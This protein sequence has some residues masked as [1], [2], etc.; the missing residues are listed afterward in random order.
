MR[1][2][3]C[4]VARAVFWLRGVEYARRITGHVTATGEGERFGFNVFRDKAFGRAAGSDTALELRV[5]RV[6]S[7]TR[8][9]FS[10]RRRN[11]DWRRPASAKSTLTLQAI[12]SLA[13][14]H[15]TL[16]VSGEESVAQVGRTCQSF[17]SRPVQHRHGG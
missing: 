13:K 10:A 7:G 12:A 1:R 11:T 4:K 3:R 9:W 17:G 8:R 14:S 2:D 5:V 16:Y 15:L 6:R